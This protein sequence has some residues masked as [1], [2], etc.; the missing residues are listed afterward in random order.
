MASPCRWAAQHG[1][2]PSKA[3]RSL[4]GCTTALTS[5]PSAPWKG[6]KRFYREN[7]NCASKPQACSNIPYC[8]AWWSMRE[9]RNTW[10]IF[11]RR[12]GSGKHISHRANIPGRRRNYLQGIASPL[13]RPLSRLNRERYVPFASKLMRFNEKSPGSDV[14]I[15]ENGAGRPGCQRPT[16]AAN[17]VVVC[18]NP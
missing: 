9:G 7:P 8:A 4:Y 10:F 16:S 1:V 6:E 5:Q 17:E 14:L 15:P 3:K 12:N 11:C 13:K 2:Y 18:P